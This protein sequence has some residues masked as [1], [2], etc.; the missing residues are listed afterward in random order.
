MPGESHIS[1][2]SISCRRSAIT[3][4]Q[5]KRSSFNLTQSRV[6]SIEGLS[7]LFVV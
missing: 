1:G 7:I 4:F 5:T 6:L 2:K 3:L